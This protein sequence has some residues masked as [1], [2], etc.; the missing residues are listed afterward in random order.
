MILNIDSLSNENKIDLYNNFEDKNV[1]SMLYDDLK[2][3]KEYSY[4]SI[5]NSLTSFD[6]NSKS[7]NIDLFKKYGV[8]IYNLYGEPF[9]MLVKSMNPISNNDSNNYINLEENESKI[10]RGCYSLI[11]SDNIDVFNRKFVYGFNN[12]NTQN[13]I[14]S[15]LT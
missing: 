2:T 5:K 3:L 6:S 7:K 14:S 9:Y 13:I 4:I 1:S 11:G 15:P 12:F 8:N 10:D